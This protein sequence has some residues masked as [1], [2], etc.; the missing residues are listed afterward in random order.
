MQ[1]ILEV[2][3]GIVSWR[4]CWCHF[5]FFHERNEWHAYRKAAAHDSDDKSTPHCRYKSGVIK[6]TCVNADHPP[7][8]I[9]IASFNVIFFLLL[10]KH[11]AAQMLLTN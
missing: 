1:Q 6:G 7:R 8:S 2:N 9:E 5:L 11:D 4:S 3:L 10:E